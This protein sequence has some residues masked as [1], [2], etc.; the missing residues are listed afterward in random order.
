M[1]S[2]QL[3]HLMRTYDQQNPT[4]QKATVEAVMAAIGQNMDTLVRLAERFRP[5]YELA[6]S[7]PEEEFNRQLREWCDG[8]EAKF[9]DTINMIW[10]IDNWGLL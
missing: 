1:N 5:I 2:K 4:Q 7:T 6:K 10:L 8:D 9:E 3:R